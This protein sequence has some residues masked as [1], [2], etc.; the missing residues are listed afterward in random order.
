MRTSLINLTQSKTPK[1]LVS[2]YS[3]HAN[4]QS[5][6]LD[7][8]SSYMNMDSHY[9][10]A[11]ASVEQAQQLI[12]NPTSAA[13]LNLG[14][15]KVKEAQKH[16]DAL[17]IGFLNDWPEYRYWWYDSRFSIYGFNSAR[18]KIGQLGAKVFQEDR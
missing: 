1:T 12:E 14:E 6:L 3:C 10:Q 13:D 7:R 17:P 18:S 8:R 11:I 5:P 9:R 2:T 15:Q 4:P 16:L